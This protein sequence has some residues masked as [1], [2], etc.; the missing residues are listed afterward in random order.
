MQ[1]EQALSMLSSRNHMKGL[2]RTVEPLGLA[3][4]QLAGWRKLVDTF[5]QHPPGGVGVTAGTLQRH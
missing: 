4:V 2:E 1:G 5:I 3:L